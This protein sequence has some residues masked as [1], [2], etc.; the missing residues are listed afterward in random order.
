MTQDNN[1]PL[2]ER[3]RAA[4]AKI[5]RGHKAWMQGREQWVDGTLELAAVIADSRKQYPDHNTFSRWLERQGLAKMSKDD[6]AA[7]LNIAAADQVAMRQELLASTSISW[8]MIWRNHRLAAPSKRPSKGPLSRESHRS[9]SARRKRAARIPDVMRDDWVRPVRPVVAIKGLTPKEV[10]PDYDG[11]YIKHTAK[12]G[13]VQL[14]TKAEIEE[15]K[16]Q[17]ALQNWLGAIASHVRTAEALLACALPD[18]E[19]LAKWLK[20]P[21]KAA[22]MRAWQEILMRAEAS[23]GAGGEEQLLHAL[24]TLAASGLTV[25][26][27]EEPKALPEPAND[28]HGYEH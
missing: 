25:Q 5:G 17:E 9:G 24:D 11:D 14:H 7:L 16:R 13:P 12:Y 22:K 10:D 1:D 26:P 23:I 4:L 28:G 3:L 20:A 8:I 18:P 6:R 21:S 19:M 15:S 2:A 27:L